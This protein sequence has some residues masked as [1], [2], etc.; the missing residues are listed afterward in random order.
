MKITCF[1][2]III[3]LCFTLLII[4]VSQEPGIK[5]IGLT[6]ETTQAETI[7]NEKADGGS[8]EKEALEKYRR[9]FRSREMISTEIR[10]LVAG[11]NTFAVNLYKKLGKDGGNLFFS[12]FSISTA[13]AMTY[14]GARNGTAVQMKKTLHFTLPQENLHPAF[15][16]LNRE[17]LTHRESDRYTGFILHTANALWV[18]KGFP[19]LT[20]YCTL[21]KRNYGSEAEYLDF[22]R[23]PEKSRIIIN[24]WVSK[25]TEYKINNIISPGALS[26][27][28]QVV[29]T[30]AIYFEA[31]WR[32]PFVSSTTQDGEFYLLDG[33][34][35]TV[36]MM[37][38]KGEFGYTGGT[39]FQ[40]LEKPYRVNM[41]MV[42][43]LPRAD[44]F[45]EFEK[46]FTP[47]KVQAI[48]ETFAWRT[49]IVKLPKF[50]YESDSIRLKN[51]LSDLGMSNVFTEFADFSG[52]APGLFIDKVLHKATV[53]VNEEG[54][55]AAAATVVAMA[56][57]I[58]SQ[59]PIEFTVNR[60]F[61]FVI[62]DMQTGTI[63]FIGRIVNP[64][65]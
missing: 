8:Q 29:L 53:T 37:A 10:E 17:L 21:L 52:I 41:S 2:R 19:V 40:A 48:I 3:V 51:V 7:Q 22:R 54:T 62:R 39:N 56:T 57:G 20:D 64:I 1:P 59:T 65:E 25:H 23:D 38:Q 44:F 35:I 31:K 49:V 24:D 18:Q 14:A 36:P 16:E 42:I 63:L 46:S 9:N 12:P 60:P 4:T 27:R 45:E 47:E 28:I 32:S 55:V 15:H 50:E 61:I 33:S 34:R 26:S 11:N 13:L 58:P 43:I 5:D 30:N 6:P